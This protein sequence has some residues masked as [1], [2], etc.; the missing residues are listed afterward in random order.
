MP[1]RGA[2]NELGQFAL[3][4]LDRRAA[5]ILP[6]KLDQVE[7]AEHRGPAIPLPPDKLEHGETVIVGDDRLAVD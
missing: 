6:L 4:V 5:Q 7:G 1:G 3:A 2:A